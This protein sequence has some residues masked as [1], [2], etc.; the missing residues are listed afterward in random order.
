M[1]GIIKFVK[2]GNS[3][4]IRVPKKT[5]ESLHVSEGTTAELWIENNALVIRPRDQS[6]TLDGLL[7]GI[8]REN[9]HAEQGP[10]KAIGAE[11]ID[12]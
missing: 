6:V 10:S 1:Q 11:V 5:V 12:E 3:L 2:I 7:A 4:S 8:T 9:L